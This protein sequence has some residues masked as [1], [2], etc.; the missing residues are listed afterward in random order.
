LVIIMTFM[1]LLN[2]ALVIGVA[3][4][5]PARAPL[6]QGAPTSAMRLSTDPETRLRGVIAELARGAPDLDAMEPALRQA[7]EPAIAPTAALLRELGAL[8]SLDPAGAQNGLTLFTT[9]FEKG[10][11]TFGIRIAPSGKLA[12]LFYRPQPAVETTGDEVTVAGLAGTLLK[13]NVARPPVVLLIAGSGPSDRNGK[14]GGGGAA[15]LRALAEALAARGIASLRF[16]KRGVGR[17]ATD[18]HE[19]DFTLDSFV[20]DAAA[21]LTWLAARDDLGPRYVAGH[22]EGG[23]IG[24][25][26]ARRMEVAGLILLATPGRRLSDVL[27]TQLADVAM[28]PALRDEAF[29]A[30]AALER[31]ESVTNVSAPLLPLLRPSVQPLLRS[32]IAMDPAREF[33]QANTPALIVSGGH[34]LQ[35][36]APDAAALIKARPDAR[37]FRAP[38]M[39]HVLKNAPAGRA[40]Q[41]A[42]YTDPRLPLAPGLADAIADFVKQR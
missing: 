39:N 7:M 32:E 2:L 14:Q 6:A 29:A 15:P 9:T 42:A 34:D 10:V 13:P 31:G 19:A 35:V 20:N 41:Q 23:L 18:V 33:A 37:V 17:S 16:D 1:R 4:A 5:V 22:S 28:P 40:E 12:A 27:R 3:V 11:V 8:A 38:E 36:T 24:I 21:W 25:R 30:L 26:L